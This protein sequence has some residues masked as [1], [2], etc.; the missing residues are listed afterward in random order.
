MEIYRGIFDQF[1]MWHFVDDGNLYFEE[2]S[3]KILYMPRARNL[4][5]DGLTSLGVF[6][7]DFQDSNFSPIVTIEFIKKKKK[8]LIK[9]GKTYM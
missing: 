5:T 7:E 6:N 4:S 2:D 3:N 8:N 9:L 1:F